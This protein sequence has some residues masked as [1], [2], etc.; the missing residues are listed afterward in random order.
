MIKIFDP[1]LTWIGQGLRW[2]ESWSGNYVSAL[3]IFAV[4]VEILLIPFG[5]KQQKNSIRQAKLRPKEMA[6]RNK[7]K[8][9][10]DQVTRQKMQ[11]EISEFYQR[12]NFNP[13]SGCLPLLIQLPIIMV[14]YQI[15]I[16]PLKY[17][18]GCSTG[19][20]N[21]II[22]R[23]KELSEGTVSKLN[24]SNTI[25]VINQIKD[26][27]IDKFED[28]EGL[29]SLAN[30]PNFEVFGVNLGLIPSS[31]GLSI[32]LLVPVLVFV[33]QYITSKLTR[34][35]TYQAPAAQDANMGCSN[36]VMDIT[37]PLM[38]TFFAFTFPA[39]IGIYWVAKNILS[40]TKQ[41]ILA[42][43]MPMPVFT[44]EDYKAA[45]KEMNAKAPKKSS[46]VGNGGSGKKVRSLHHIDDED[47]E[48]T[49]TKALPEK[50]NKENE[51]EKEPADEASK[52]ENKG[53]LASAPIK[54]D[55]PAADRTKKRENG[56]NKEE[57]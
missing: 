45:E 16:N 15:V 3:L 55:I 27:G 9:R 54:E 44:E 1:I 12:E 56:K 28:I 46:S 22:E 34:K 4:I 29:P 30:L 41:I 53:S 10:N 24:A 6:I 25:E 57:K 38:S 32:L 19:Q 50:N 8:G 36:N 35:F 37:M 51:E 18:V 11:Q 2:F 7:Y 20:I 13:A 43:I 14:L 23:I 39:A 33:F 17:V 42:K 40:F 31:Q 21:T 5:I 48:D 47:F 26:C 52:D 49:C